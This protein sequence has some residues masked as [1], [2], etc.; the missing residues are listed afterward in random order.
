MDQQR[1]G[2]LYSLECGE[3]NNSGGENYA[4]MRMHLRVWNDFLAARA[5]YGVIEVAGSDTD[6]D[7]LLDTS[8]RIRRTP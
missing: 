7:G 4:G 8:I 6:G 3:P 5:Y 2:D 1:A